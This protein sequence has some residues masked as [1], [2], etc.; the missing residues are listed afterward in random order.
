MNPRHHSKPGT[1]LARAQKAAGSSE[2]HVSGSGTAADAEA[3]VLSSPQGRHL[4]LEIESV[5]SLGPAQF[6][7]LR[8]HVSPEAVAAAVRLTLARRKAATKFERGSSMWVDP[9]GVEQA[10]AQPV[11]IHK[12]RRF[13]CNLVV[14]LCA[15]IGSDTIALAAR[16]SVLS[17]DLD[18]GMCRRTRFNASLHGVSDRV[19]AIR[20]RA[21]RFPVPPGA[22]V[23]LDPD[24]RA[25]LTRRALRLVDYS[26]GPPFWSALISSAP[27]GAIKL[28]PASDFSNHFAS[29]NVEIELISL[30]GECKEAT[31]WF[32]TLASCR[33]RAT[34][35][36]ENIT[37]TDHQNPNN[38]LAPVAP[39]GSYIYDPDP[40]LVRAGLLD[41][42]AC[43]HNLIRFSGGVDYLT[44][45]HLVRTPFLTAFEVH[46]VSSLDHKALKRLIAKHQ[47]GTLEIK[48]R[49]VGMRPEAL[50]EK[51]KPSGTHAATLLVSGGRTASIAILAQ[52]ISAGGLETSS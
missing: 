31:V 1:A 5:Q 43:E 51:L 26:P 45:H 47:I 7:R 11:A 33:R 41:G 30:R 13:E 20:A 4:L 46:E 42:F 34:R 28:S 10:T 29:T 9:T 17:V 16:S 25:S 19:L 27:A 35:L 2:A 37:W 52:R 18:Q 48:V 6:T 3:W 12:A 36:P 40:S 23:H 32:G 24:R 14:D 39:L 38:R 49:G 22:W 44:A 8:Q 50:R 15:G 21:E